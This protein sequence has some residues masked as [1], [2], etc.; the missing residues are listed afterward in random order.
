MAVGPF[1]ITPE[2]DANTEQ[3]RK[4]GECALIETIIKEKSL[5]IDSNPNPRCLLAIEI[6]ISGG[7]KTILGDFTNA[8]MMGWVG[9]VVGKKSDSFDRIQ[10][11]VQYA[12][13]LRDVKKANLFLNTACYTIEEFKALLSREA[14]A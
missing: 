3:I 13:T 11:V 5:A 12:R 8:S 4:A 10:S 14:L 6:E 7:A 1:N 9:V 2:R